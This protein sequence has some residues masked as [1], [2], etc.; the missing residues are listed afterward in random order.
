MAHPI[1]AI[2]D[3]DLAVSCLPWKPRQLRSRA[4][5]AKAEPL[6]H[7]HTATP[8]SHVQLLRKSSTAKPSTEV[9]S[10]MRQALQGIMKYRTSTE[11]PGCGPGRRSSSSGGMARLCLLCCVGPHGAPLVLNRA[12]PPILGPGAAPLSKFHPSPSLGGSRPSPAL[13][14]HPRRCAELS[15]GRNPQG[16][17]GDR[18]RRTQGCA[19]PASRHQLAPSPPRTELGAGAAAGLGSRA[20]RRAP[21]KRERGGARAVRRAE[22]KGG[23]RGTPPRSSSSP[24][25]GRGEQTCN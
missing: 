3:P 5:P 19:T 15:A 7:T 4:W 21:G 10:R 13:H 12:T 14:S 8:S 24:S 18:R 23:S 20:W 6:G 9:A 17:L 25:P 1:R 22:K 11:T 2:K 16:G